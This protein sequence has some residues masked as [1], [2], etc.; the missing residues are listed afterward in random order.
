MLQKRTP[1]SSFSGLNPWQ[2]RCGMRLRDLIFG[3][4]PAWGQ[5][6]QQ[7]AWRYISNCRSEATDSR[8]SLYCRLTWNRSNGSL[9]GNIHGW[10]KEATPS[11]M[12]T[13]FACNILSTRDPILWFKDL[14]NLQKHLCMRCSHHMQENSWECKISRGFAISFCI[15]DRS[16]STSE[17]SHAYHGV[18]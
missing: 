6:Y 14:R 11:G 8:C 10:C 9:G 5:S 4:D 18:L 2:W 13:Y 15:S 17:A 7:F 3:H 1:S 12:M 16:V